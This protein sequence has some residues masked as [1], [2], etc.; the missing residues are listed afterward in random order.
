MGALALPVLAGTA[1]AST[2]MT[3][4]GAIHQAQAQAGAA[5]YNAQ[6]AQQNSQI[7]DAQS[8]AASD[9]QQRDSQRKIGAAMAAYGASGVQMSEGS[10]ADVLAE[11]AR[12]ATLDNLTLK[13][14]YKLRGLGYQNQAALDYSNASNYRM[15][16]QL[17]ATAALLGGASKAA[18]YMTFGTPGGGGVNDGS[19]GRG[20]GAD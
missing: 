19:W 6:I 7:A 1:V 5:E 9:A 17:G 20:G 8:A 14:N 16:G 15:A 3:A 12:M 2:I 13:Y 11:S 10:P 18:G 4:V